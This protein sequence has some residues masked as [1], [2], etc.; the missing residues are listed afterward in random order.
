MP[1]AEVGGPK[2]FEA[3]PGNEIEI[4][5]RLR[6][7]SKSTSAYKRVLSSIRTF[8]LFIA[9][10]VHEH[11]WSFY[12]LHLFY[13]ILFIVFF[14]SFHFYGPHRDPPSGHP[15][16]TG[17]EAA[18]GSARASS[19]SSSGSSGAGVAVRLARRPAVLQRH[20]QRRTWRPQRPD[21]V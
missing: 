5:Q 8:H 17:T 21:R 19:S 15:W 10:T 11:W 6:K 1:T 12:Y 4:R 16:S 3:C 7:E 2:R 18:W 14:I 9:H 20:D 13:F